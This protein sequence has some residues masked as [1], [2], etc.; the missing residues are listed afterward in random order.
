MKT[1]KNVIKKVRKTCKNRRITNK[2]PIVSI[3]GGT[4]GN[5]M[6]GIYIVKHMLSNRKK[7]KRNGFETLPFIANPLAVS[8]QTRFIDTD[9]NRIFTK[10]VLEGHD[11]INSPYE[12]IRARQI[13]H[14]LKDSSIILDLHNTTANS[15]TMII[16][17][18]TNPLTFYLTHML[19]LKNS[20]RKVWLNKP[21]KGE[22]SAANLGSMASCNIGVEIGPD[23]GHGI[24]TAKIF[25]E[26]EDCVNDFLDICQSLFTKNKKSIIPKFTLEVY[27]WIGKDVLFPLNDEGEKTAL[28]HPN[29]QSSDYKLLKNGDPIFLHFDGKVETWKGKDVYPLFIEEVSYSLKPPN[30]NNKNVAFYPCTI[31]KITCPQIKVSTLLKQVL[32]NLRC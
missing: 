28:I 8:R 15:G 6:M 2:Q 1:H 24:C 16:I 5:E 10:K 14:T 11:S 12:E 26:G 25:K 17:G 19:C 18:D 30:G 22:K 9:I 13:Y 31:E 4:H 20:Q 23:G 21:H 27:R 3:V 7:Y 29:F 32:P